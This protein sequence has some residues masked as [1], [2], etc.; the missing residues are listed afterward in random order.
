MYMQNCVRSSFEFMLRQNE[1]RAFLGKYLNSQG[2]VFYA[3]R[4]ERLWFADCCLI[5]YFSKQKRHVKRKKQLAQIIET[6]STAYIFTNVLCT[7][8]RSTCILR[9]S[10][11]GFFWLFRCPSHTWAHIKYPS[12]LCVCTRVYKH[13]HTY[14]P[15]TRKNREIYKTNPLSLLLP[16]H[17]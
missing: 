10:R 11:S 7:P 5:F 6:R 1:S 13:T 3:H 14:H 15:N 8:I 4:S 9:F 17:W 12:S 16:K 2:V